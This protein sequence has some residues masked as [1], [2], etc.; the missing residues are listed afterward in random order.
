MSD[1]RI[2]GYLI[3][4][5]EYPCDLEEAVNASVQLGWVPHGSMVFDPGIPENSIRAASWYQPMV[6]YAEPEPD[7]LAKLAYELAAE[8]FDGDFG[9]PDCERTARKILAIKAKSEGGEG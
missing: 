9:W 7:E 2:I 1:W 5:A 8:V 4:W 6:R 3:K